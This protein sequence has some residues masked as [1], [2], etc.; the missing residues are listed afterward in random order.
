MCVCVLIHLLFDIVSP[1]PS[2]EGTISGY[3]VLI[4]ML[5]IVPLRVTS[6]IKIHIRY[7]FLEVRWW[8]HAKPPHLRYGISSKSPLF[9]RWNF[10][11][12]GRFGRPT[13]VTSRDPLFPGGSSL[14]FPAA[15]ADPPPL[16]ARLRRGRRSAWRSW[17]GRACN[18]EVVL[19]QNVSRII[20]GWFMDIP[21][22]YG[23]MILVK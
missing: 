4:I 9:W 23:I 16:D 19:I 12:S 14:W 20:N 8:S 1:F 2:C 7:I 13:S 3:Y 5:H 17:G 22:L 11:M 15:P 10:I 21:W 18:L 6:Y